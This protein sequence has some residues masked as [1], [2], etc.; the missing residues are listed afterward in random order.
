MDNKIEEYIENIFRGEAILFV[1]AGFSFDNI[2]INGNNIPN[3][4][5]LAELLQVEAGLKEIDTNYDLGIVSDYYINE[6]GKSEMVKILNQ[7]YIVNTAQKWQN[8]ILKFPWYRI[9]TTNYDNV[10]EVAS[11]SAGVH[12]KGISVGNEE[13]TPFNLKDSIVHIN[14][15]ID[16][17]SEENIETSTKLTSYSYAD[18]NFING[19]WNVELTDNFM[20]AKSIFFI[21]FSMSYDLD[22]KRIVASQKYL[23]DKIF[24]INGKNN[25]VEKVALEKYGNVL[26]LNGE[27]F[28]E[29]ISSQFVDFI[30][31]SDKKIRTYSFKKCEISKKPES[32]NSK[33]VSDLFFLG[34]L[35][36]DKLNY[37]YRNSNYLVYR[38]KIN[39]IIDNLDKFSLFFVLSRLGNGKTLFLKLLER[40]LLESNYIVYKY[41]K[42]PS[43]IYEDVQN[44]NT[45]TNE[46]CIILIDDYYSIRSSFSYLG[47]LD[48][49]KYKIIVTGRSGLHENNYLDFLNKLKIPMEEVNTLKIDKIDTKEAN[50]LKEIVDSN[51]LWGDL[52][53]KDDDYKNE[54]IAKQTQSGIGNFVIELVKSTNIMSK[55]EKLYSSFD[56]NTKRI[57]LCVLINNILST[58]LNIQDILKLTNNTAMSDFSIKDPNLNEFLDIDRNHIIF[59]SAKA[60]GELLKKEKNRVLLVDLLV[61]MLKQANNLDSGLNFYKENS[62]KLKEKYNYLK[63]QIISFSNFRM[64]NQGIGED[65]LN[66]LA[67]RYYE[68]I[69]N[70]KFAKENPF[71]WLQFG[72]QRLN[73]ENYFLADKYF[74]NALSY[75]GKKG[76]NDFYQINAQ[77][78]RGILEDK[79]KNEEDVKIAFNSFHEAHSLLVKDL[80]NRNNNKSYQ[81]TQGILYYKFYE[82]FKSSFSIGQSIKYRSYVNQYINVVEGYLMY[83]PNHKL[84]GDSYEQ[85]RK[86]IF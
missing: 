39:S 75:A 72:I 47:K 35:E 16:E 27:K 80:E 23:R 77:K 71:F 66:N 57:I 15:F 86:I 26:N 5:K 82:K 46:N 78:A 53:S 38:E 83:N 61:D 10:L 55:Y 63:R 49:K 36:E 68:Y 44:L 31:L 11:E 30:P 3:A 51:N 6:K 52:A 42:N 59:Q 84:V 12:R 21:G 17:I 58:G 32:I 7:H 85:L 69:Q 40:R 67:V 56:L 70:D 50:Q 43:N 79:I 20:Y 8:E 29:K 22:I 64:L 37:N 65:E 60:S 14:G 41:N 25:P 73:E 2:N 4:K 18:S 24:F 13:S 76:I 28:S 1:G 81:L 34:N 54:F 62:T 9:Y 33:D 74:E 45:T 48:K 19:P